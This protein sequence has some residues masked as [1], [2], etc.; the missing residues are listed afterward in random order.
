M[1]NK[2]SWSSSL[3][4]ASLFTA[5]SLSLTGCG[6]GSKSDADYYQEALQHYQ[7]KNN[8]AAIIQLKNALSENLNHADS[9]KLLGIIYAE[10]GSGADA[11]KELRQAL[12]LGTP[13]EQIGIWL[14]DAL[15]LQGKSDELLETFQTQTSDSAELRAIKAL[16]SGEAYLQQRV[17]KEAKDQF[18]TA[19]EYDATKPRA[20]LGL[21]LI[22]VIESKPE[23]AQQLVEESLAIDDKS[24]KAWLTQGDIHK[25]GGELEAA[26]SAYQKGAAATRIPQSYYYQ[27]AMRQIMELQL[28]TGQLAAAEETLNTLKNSFHQ[29]QYP[30]D[31]KLTYLRAV[32]AFQKQNFAEASE[33]AGKVLLMNKNHL[34]AKLLAGTADAAI[35]NYRKATK[36]LRNYLLHNPNNYQARKVL[37]FVQTK[38]QEYQEAIDTL[39]PITES[40]DE[41]DKA[42]LGIIATSALGA[43]DVQKSTEYLSEALE[44]D[45]ANSDLR[46]RLAQSFLA[47]G[48]FDR[49]LEELSTL[50]SSDEQQQRPK[51][52]KAK[53]YI[54]AE[55]Y[56][57]ALAILQP[58]AKE[59]PDDPEIISLEGTVHYLMGDTSKA[60]DS[61]LHARKIDQGYLPAIRSLAFLATVEGNPDQAESVYQSALK[62][63]P[64]NPNLLIELG[65][66]LLQQQ[67]LDEAE[68]LFKRAK[69]TEGAQMTASVFLARL[70]IAEQK[71]D[72]AKA[73]L[74]PH[75]S[76][77]SPAVFAELGNAQM[78]S[79]EYANAL[80]SYEKLASLVPNSP[81]A[82]YLVASAYSALGNSIAAD[83]ALGQSLSINNSFTPAVLAKARLAL[84]NKDLPQ[85]KTLLQTLTT[86]APE[87]ITTKLLA[88]DIAMADNQ[89]ASAYQIY[90]KLYSENPNNY[91]LPQM[92]QALW[93]AEGPEAVI[94]RLKQITSNDPENIAAYTL[95]ASAYQESGKTPEAIT[96]YKKVIDQSP[97]NAIALNNLA[98]LLKDSA[99]KEAQTYAKKALKLQPESEAIEDTLEQINLL[100]EE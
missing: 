85:A 36:N 9:R 3:W 72:L 49:A 52:A 33:L 14:G 74:S 13:F 30:Q 38:N 4:L 64:D 37:A 95:L 21:A 62:A 32:L 15:L 66:L 54:N 40:G 53:V 48:D 2:G 55:D 68:E 63:N 57:N 94:P 42:T 91:L 77:E 65:Q 31:I 59:H 90:Q 79:R 1:F 75:T 39:A 83:A 70:Y 43:G 34:G 10:Q 80:A 45:P 23:Q 5:I 100:L 11:E 47:Q 12:S 76:S 84:K 71:P 99:P 69:Q 16:M 82:P 78:L 87:Q 60:R 18:T 56:D 73:E 24:P 89:P 20:L 98:W 6:F 86:N 97:D 25:L 92:V 28:S 27:I 8:Q 35:G 7:Q 19:T 93:R 41:L 58:L 50:E 67:K 22:A 29:G 26:L 51:I 81:I 61:F 88:A 17:Y 46:Y 44:L 96:T